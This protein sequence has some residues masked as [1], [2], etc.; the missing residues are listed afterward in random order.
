M[1]GT[2]DWAGSSVSSSTPGDVNGGLGSGI[3]LSATGFSSSGLCTR[4]SGGEPY[5]IFYFLDVSI[6]YRFDIGYIV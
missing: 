6:V 4:V 5:R 1:V 3:L 2:T